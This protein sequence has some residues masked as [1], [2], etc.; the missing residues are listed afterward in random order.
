[1]EPAL[2][3]FCCYA[4]RDQSL[5]NELK[6]HLMPLQHQGLITIWADTDID[7]GIEWG[8]E[9]EKHLD[10]AQIILLLV[11]P[12]F[13]S[14]E[15][16]YSKEM[17]RAMER[18]QNGEAR[19]I[20]IILRSV[21]WQDAPFGKLQALPTKAQPVISSKWHDSDEAFLDIVGRIRRVIKEL[22]PVHFKHYLQ[23]IVQAYHKALEDAS[24][25]GYDV[26]PECGSTNLR[27]S[28]QLI[29]YVHDE[30]YDF[31]R[32]KD[33]GWEGEGELASIKAL[34]KNLPF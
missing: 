4:H 30:I 25:F 20:P 23:E 16:C 33:C 6:A 9:I 22:T 31:I 7:A 5:L 3:I 19:V 15:H 13:M 1:M 34:R 24:E 29:D 18:H 10:A 14:S 21:A 11:S 26:C 28:E 17:K 8:K 32:C 12:D 2:E 27:Q